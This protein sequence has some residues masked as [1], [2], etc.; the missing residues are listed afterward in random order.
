M[1]IACSLIEV[2][3]WKQCNKWRERIADISSGHHAGFTVEQLEF[4]H[5][6]KR[7]YIWVYLAMIIAF[8]SA[9]TL[10]LLLQRY[11][12]NGVLSLTPGLSCSSPVVDSDE[13][14]S[15]ASSGGHATI[16]RQ[17]DSRYPTGECF[18]CQEQNC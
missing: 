14:S 9:I 1:G 16:Y 18:I 12:C 13:T 2:H 5:R 4:E 7:G 6:I 11:T 10:V 3:I 8:G 15:I 17:Y